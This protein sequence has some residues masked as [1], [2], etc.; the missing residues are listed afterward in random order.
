LIG[1]QYLLAKT[2]MA[3]A[4]FKSGIAPMLAEDVSRVD[5]SQ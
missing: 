2:T 3:G 1:W 4:F 5:G